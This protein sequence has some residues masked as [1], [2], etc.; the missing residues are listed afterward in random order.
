MI[1]DKKLNGILD[2]GNNCLIV[3][4]DPATDVRSGCRFVIPSPVFDSPLSLFPLCS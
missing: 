4:D 2:Q 1:L 3:F